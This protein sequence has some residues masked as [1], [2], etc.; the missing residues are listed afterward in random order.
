M[1]QTLEWGL[2]IRIFKISWGN[3][4]VQPWFTTG[5]AVKDN[6][7][8]LL[9]ELSSILFF[10]NDDLFMDKEAINIEGK[11]QEQIVTNHQS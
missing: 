3:I 10:L 9:T 5:L 6:C 4:T 2:R 8:S 11:E 7:V 1:L